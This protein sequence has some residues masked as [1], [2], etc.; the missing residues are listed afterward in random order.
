MILEFVS[1]KLMLLQ[2]IAVS[3]VA[4]YAVAAGRRCALPLPL[5]MLYSAAA[6]TS[7]RAATAAC[8]SCSQPLLPNEGYLLAAADSVNNI[9]LFCECVCVRLVYVCV[10]ACI[11]I[12]GC[13][14]R[15]LWL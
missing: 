10:F 9:T 8:C 6:A 4:V 12:S 7:A 2:N 1:F 11:T 13:K 15:I 3:V 14:M 5:Q